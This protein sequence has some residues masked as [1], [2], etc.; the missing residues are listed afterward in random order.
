M[1]KYTDEFRYEVVQEYLNG[2]MGFVALGKQHD[3]DH[4]MIRRWVGWYQSHGVDGLRK[5]FTYYS[6]EFKLS[7]LTYIW[8]NAVSH[9][10]TAA[11]FNIRNLGILS[12][13]ERLYLDGGLDALQPRRRGRTKLMS[14]P[15]TKPVS[16]QADEQTCH[17]ALLKEVNYLRAENAYLKKL[18][19]LVHSKQKQAQEKKRK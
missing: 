2:K 8:D 18:R 16:N 9:R 7:V 11:H 14:A 15:V 12:Q 19:A 3:L 17:D 6:A 13:W 5:K 10:Q 1:T 4:S